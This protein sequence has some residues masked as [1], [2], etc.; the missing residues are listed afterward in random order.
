M[1]SMDSGCI[2]FCSTKILQI[3]FK[4]RWNKIINN[5]FRNTFIVNLKSNIFRYHLCDFVGGWSSPKYRAHSSCGSP[6][7]VLSSAKVEGGNFQDLWKLL[8]GLLAV[9]FLSGVMHHNSYICPCFIH[10]HHFFFPLSFFFHV[11]PIW[12]GFVLKNVFMWL[13]W[14]GPNTK[15]NVLKRFIRISVVWVNKVIEKKKY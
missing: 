5:Y 7:Q 11:C 4:V 10:M 2:H 14:L 3:Y 13:F 15:L 12:M 1:T 8:F 9:D 6:D